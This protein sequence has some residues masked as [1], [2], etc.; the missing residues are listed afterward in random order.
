[1]IRQAKISDLKTILKLEEKAFSSD[2]FS[3]NQF[4][5]LLTKANSEFLVY[6]DNNKDVV[7]Y[8]IG[9]LRH[10]AQNIRIY[11]AVVSQDYQKQGIG[12]KLF[13]ELEKMATKKKLNK[14]TLEVRKDRT[15]LIEIYQHFGYQPLKLLENYYQDHMSA[16]KMQKI[17]N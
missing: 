5:Y 15:D 6:L 12:K 11:S 14:I 17:I 10:N 4:R 16:L 2:R 8:I 1:M 7:G 13:L 3:K 9:L